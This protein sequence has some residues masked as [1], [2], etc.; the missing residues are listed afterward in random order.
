MMETITFT[1]AEFKRAK[2]IIAREGP[3]TMA[4]AISKAK[5]EL[6]PRG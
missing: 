2:E 5:T 6:A 3:M 4:E 1:K